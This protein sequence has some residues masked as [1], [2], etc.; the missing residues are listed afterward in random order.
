VFRPRLGR[1]PTRG[2]VLA[3]TGAAATALMLLCPSWCPIAPAGAPRVTIDRYAPGGLDARANAAT[4]VM[5]RAEALI[6]TAKAGSAVS[7]EAAGDVSGLV[8][9]EWSP[10][11]TT[12]GTLESKRT[13]TDPLWASVLTRRLSA[14]GIGRGDLVAAGFSG[15]FPGLNLAVM[16]AA[17]ALGADLVAVSSV[18]ASTWGANQPGFT[19]PEIE[20]RVV[21]AGLLPRASAA[22]TAGGDDDSGL[23][24]DPD[25]R[26]LAA[27]TRDQAASCLGAAVLRPS[28]FRDAVGQRLSLYQRS[29]RGRPVAL[30]VN[31]G[32]TAASLGRSE[33]VLRLR[34]G[35][36]PAVSFDRSEDRGVMARFAEQHVRV[37]T[38][39]NVRDLALRWGIPLG[40]KAP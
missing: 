3:A 33:A 22:V 12:M 36:V 5:R 40:G 37:L 9:S 39:L 10:L 4:E 25:A 2:V 18:T 1:V 7:A 30:Y 23:G 13:A 15:S 16:A 29:A 24:L 6:R 35:F 19:W 14:E 31:V 27:R 8:G 21:G 17:R 26:R 32:G 34:S 20:C 38:L 28:S 11:V